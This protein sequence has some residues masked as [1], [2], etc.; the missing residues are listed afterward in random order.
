[1]PDM[2]DSNFSDL[3]TDF[4]RLKLSVLKY[5]AFLINLKTRR[6]KICTTLN[7]GDIQIL[8]TRKITLSKIQKTPFLILSN[9][10]PP[11]QT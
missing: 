3:K 6:N 4:S 1:M 5:P 10:S 7:K 9:I 11:N 8:R 2:L